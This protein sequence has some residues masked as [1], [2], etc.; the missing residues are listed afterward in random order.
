MLKP[1]KYDPLNRSIAYVLDIIGEGWTI[2]IIRE[3][4]FGTRRFEDFQRQ[5]S[6]ARNIL[7][8]RLK[9]LCENGILDRVLIKQG[10]K[11]HEYVLTRKGKELMPLL[12]A[13]TQWGDKWFPGE[14]AEPIIFMDKEY[15]EPIADIKVYSSRGRQLRPRDIMV[16]AGPGASAEAKSRIDEL[17]LLLESGD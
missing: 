3:V 16:V 13:L 12:V 8:S 15:R 11:R 6:I 17:N 1:E 10:G 5:L 7:S 2:L 4:Y 9:K 14:N